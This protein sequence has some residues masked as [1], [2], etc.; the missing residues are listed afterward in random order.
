M[1]FMQPLL[2]IVFNYFCRLPSFK[3][4]ALHFRGKRAAGLL[5]LTEL[6]DHDTWVLSP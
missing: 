6:L 3:E 5:F 2:K 1:T 4:T